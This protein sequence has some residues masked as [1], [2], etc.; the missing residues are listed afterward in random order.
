[1]L[2]RYVRELKIITLEDAIHKMTSFP[3]QRLGLRDRGILK[4]GMKADIAV[5]DPDTVRD[6]ATFEQ[7]HQYAEGVFLVVINGEITFENSSMTSARPGR[8]LYGPGYRP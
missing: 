5:F 1:V 6:R 2:G 7:P 3:A 4:E 8:V